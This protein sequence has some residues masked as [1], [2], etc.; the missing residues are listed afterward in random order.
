VCVHVPE[1]GAEK[2]V[3]GGSLREELRVRQHLERHAVVRG[4]EDPLSVASA[5]LTG[6]ADFSTTTLFLSVEQRDVSLSQ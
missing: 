6:T 5:V 4:G 2:V 3:H 1:R